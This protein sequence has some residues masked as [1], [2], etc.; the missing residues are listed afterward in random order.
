MSCG[1][2]HRCGSG[3][4][5]IWLC[6]WYKPATTA[7]TQPLDWELPHA[8]GSALKS[9]GERWGKDH[10]R[11]GYVPTPQSLDHVALLTTAFPEPAACEG[12]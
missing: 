3:L 1:V 8:P 12:L 7:P 6:L 9:G 10:G 5:L 11:V 4:V 2:S